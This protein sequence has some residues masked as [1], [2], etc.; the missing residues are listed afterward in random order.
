MPQRSVWQR[1]VRDPIVAQLKLGVSPDR[2]ALTLALGVVCGLFPILGLTT[3]LCFIVALLLRLNQPIIHIVNQLLWP[4]H[5]PMMA[6]YIGAGQWIR[7]RPAMPFD[8]EQASQLFR[9][10][11]QEFWLRFGALALS[12]ALAWAITTP[13]VV[14]ILYYSLRPLLRK[15]AAFRRVPPPAA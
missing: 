9:D 7:G 4:V 10:S 3:A 8:L 6:V 15:A 1:R 12:G 14:A 5:L 2:L 13:F 11:P